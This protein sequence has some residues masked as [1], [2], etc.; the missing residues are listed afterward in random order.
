[1]PPDF[2]PKVAQFTLNRLK[3]P[4]KIIISVNNYRYLGVAF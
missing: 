1:V 3:T 4:K 2:L